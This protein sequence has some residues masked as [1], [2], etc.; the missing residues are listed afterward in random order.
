[1]YT[2][3]GVRRESQATEA[4]KAAQAIQP[5]TRVT[6]VSL[7]MV[8]LYCCGFGSIAVFVMQGVKYFNSP[9]DIDHVLHEDT[10]LYKQSLQRTFTMKEMALSPPPTPTHLS[11]EQLP[12]Y[13]YSYQ[14]PFL[15]DLFLEMMQDTGNSVSDPESVMSGSGSGGENGMTDFPHGFDQASLLSP[16]TFYPRG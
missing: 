6:G 8:W 10:A 14:V 11:R 3:L 4:M 16:R 7:L 12:G 2:L 9:S 13:V 5:S 15:F 1:M